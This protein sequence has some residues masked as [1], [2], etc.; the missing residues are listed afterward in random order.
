MSWNLCVSWGN[1]AGIALAVVVGVLMTSAAPAICAPESQT[2]QES[3][4]LA[5][6]EKTPIKIGM[7][8]SLTGVATADSKQMVDGFELYL[9]KINSEVSGRKIELIVEDDE[10]RA[11]VAATRVRK[12]VEQDKVDALTG[13]F[14][15]PVAVE[16]GKLSEQYK[17]PFVD[18]V[19]S[20]DDLTQRKHPKWLVRTSWSSS[21]AGH[22]FGEYAARTLNYKRIAVVAMDYPFGYQAVGGF[23]QSFEEAGGKV[24][25]KLWMPLDGKDYRQLLKE[26]DRGVDAIYLVSVG[27]ASTILLGQLKDLGLTLPIIGYGNATD[28]VALSTAKDSALGVLTVMP[29]SAA[30][31]NPTNKKFVQA[32]RAKFGGDPGWYA[33]CGY[34]AAMMIT[35]AVESLKG[36]ISDKS[37]LLSAI[38]KSDFSDNPRGPAKFD[39]LGG[40][41][42]NI[43]LRKVEKVNGKYE[44]VVIHVFPMV[45]QFWKYNQDEYLKRPEYSKD[46]PPCT[47]CEQR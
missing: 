8:A 14:F 31:D 6:M 36:D 32:F 17:V 5:S 42:E 20:G 15:T 4:H 23:Q 3:H 18:A 33:E 9:N 46:Y 34:T 43:Y 29:Y 13:A 28:E 44:N 19:A 35:K 37:K 22:P 47:H 16:V 2:A 11:P 38:K 39:D 1:R 40:V 26:L 21:Q 7:L 10:S 25:Q 30:L 24:I 12:L 45:S 41:T 27:Q